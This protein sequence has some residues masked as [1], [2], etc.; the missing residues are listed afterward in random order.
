[1]SGKQNGKNCGHKEQ[2]FILCPFALIAAFGFGVTFCF[3]FQFA[4]KTLKY[5][6]YTLIMERIFL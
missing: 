1:V 4:D 3:T 5:R 6:S 2:K